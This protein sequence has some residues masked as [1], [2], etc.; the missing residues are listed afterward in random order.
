MLSDISTKADAD[1]QDPLV[2]AAREGFGGDHDFI[3]QSE[4]EAGIALAEYVLREIHGRHT[5]AGRVQRTHQKGG[6]P[7][8][9]AKTA[10]QKRWFGLG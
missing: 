2:G 9:A 6:L 8:T 7:N 1:Q 4:H 10:H 5:V 3:G